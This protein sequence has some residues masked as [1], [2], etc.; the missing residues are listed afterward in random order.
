LPPSERETGKEISCWKCHKA[1]PNLDEI[2]LNDQGLWMCQECISKRYSLNLLD[3]IKT[4]IAVTNTADEDRSKFVLRELV[5]NADDA[6]ASIIVLRFEKDALYVA[7]NGRAF[8]AIGPDGTPGDFERAAAVLKRFK[9]NDPE[10]AGHFGSGFQTVYA[11]TNRPEVHSNGISRALNPAEMSWENL[12]EHRYSPYM[13]GKRGKK[14]VLFRLPWRDNE[15]AAT[16]VQ[17]E[18]P[19]SDKYSWPRWNDKTIREFYDDLKEYLH[20]VLLCAQRLQTVRIVWSA[21]ATY[22]AYEASRDYSLEKPLEDVTIVHVR[23]GRASTRLSWYKW[24]KGIAQCIECP[25][26]FSPETMDSK[27]AKLHEYI[28]ASS[29]ASDESGHPQ[30][31]VRDDGGTVA[32]VSKLT[33]KAPI[34]KNHVHLL[35]PLFLTSTDSGAKS[36]HSFLYSIIPLPRRGLNS[37]VFSAHLIPMEDRKDV[38]V[39]GNAGMNGVW[40]RYCMSEVARLYR[41]VFPHFLEYAKDLSTSLSERQRIVL[42]ALPTSE[43]G[44]WMRPDTSETDWAAGETNSLR[45]WLCAQPILVTSET[46][47]ASPLAA[48]SY[49]NQEEQSLLATLD[50]DAFPNEFTS[51]CNEVPWLRKISEERRLQPSEM[52]KVWQQVKSSGTP[53]TLRY[54]SSVELP[55]GRRLSLSL[56]SLEIL[57]RYAM[58]DE[59]TASLP[60]VPNEEGTLCDIHSFP[61]L[62]EDA[63]EVYMLLSPSRRVHP[64]F[65]RLIQ[66][67]EKRGPTRR[68]ETGISELPE[69]ISL[70]VSEQPKRF[71]ELSPE[72]FHILS[73]A[74]ALIV[75]DESFASDKTVDKAFIPYRLGE[76]LYVGSPPNLSDVDSQHIAENYQRDWIFASQHT[77]VPV[78]GLT[79]EIKAKIRFLALDGISP[80]ETSKIENRLNLVALME[81]NTPTNYV[82]HFLSGL[83][84]SLLED[85]NLKKLLDSHDADSLTAQKKKMLEALKDYFSDGPHTERGLKPKDMGEITCLYDTERVWRKANEFA[86]GKGS[87]LLTSDYA[88]LHSDFDAW[89]SKILV[90]LGVQ[91]GLTSVSGIAEEVTKLAMQPER[92]R[93][94]LSNILGELCTTLD[95]TKLKQLAQLLKS[96]AWIP[97]AGLKFAKPSEALLK[98]ESTISI[99]GDDANSFVD[100]KYMDPDVRRALEELKPQDRK[101]R[102]LSI[103]IRIEPSI[104]EMFDAMTNMARRLAVPP[105][106]LLASLSI[107]FGG[108]SP[109]DSPQWR[110]RASAGE[111][112]WKGRWYSGSRI[113]ILSDKNKLPLPV[114]PLEL[115]VLTSKEAVPYRHYLDMIG[116]RNELHVDDILRALPLL[117]KGPK[118]AETQSL[119]VSLWKQIESSSSEISTETASQLAGAEIYSPHGTVLVAPENVLLDDTGFV[120]SAPTIV[121]KSCMIPK[122]EGPSAALSRLG[123][124]RISEI[125]PTK[126]QSCLINTAATNEPITAN[127]AEAYLRLLLAMKA[128]G[129]C[130]SDRA[131]PL[132]ALSYRELRFRKPN[133]CYIANAATTKIYDNVNIAICWTSDGYQVELERL[134]A[135]WG[136]KSLSGEVKYPNLSEWVRGRSHEMEAMFSQIYS[137]L[138]I[139]F[140]NNWSSLSW[141]RTLEVMIAEG[142]TQ[143]YVVGHNKGRFIIPAIIPLD[144][145]RTGLILPNN[146][147]S[148]SPDSLADIVGAW[149]I[150]CGF[151]P[152]KIDQLKPT[153][154]LHYNVAVED[155][156]RPERHEGYSP[157]LATLESWYG[158]CQICGWRTPID[159][160]SG[161]CAEDIRSIISQRGGMLRGPFEEYEVGN[162]LYLC[163]RHASLMRRG[164]IRFNFLKGKP[165]EII[166]KLKEAREHVSDTIVAQVYEWNTLDASK[167]EKGWKKCPVNLNPLHAKAIFERLPLYYEK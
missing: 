41:S 39:Q 92:N 18:R 10:A 150:G 7:N 23:E 115:L 129:W 1:P 146:I 73:R 14:G 71:R 142:K 87:P 140:E 52:K 56:E 125:G 79:N 6:N 26:S 111:F 166:E 98:T 48:Y 33:G 28:A 24:D 153:F 59:M 97:V 145:N 100:I 46:R 93:T 27:D 66:Q 3:F 81:R 62:P 110:K 94:R 151:P 120:V 90:A 77:S 9:A 108:L 103:G 85:S 86:L 155:M 30:Y 76:S 158:G 84:G 134:A 109:N 75:L 141:I 61:K 143:T 50:L 136:S 57:I 163:P 148:V 131:A 12:P 20:A 89:D 45:D 162:C 105:G 16:V 126:A 68:K 51:L 34:K 70:S 123:A 38:D 67:L 114:A 95:D 53:G 2:E 36:Q 102:F 124:I 157:T 15:A 156:Q 29:V 42:Q 65:A 60:L 35:M 21:D 138:S 137:P 99:L 17:G 139:I 83:H 80:R 55:S 13:G 31:L 154:I 117:L 37:F 135:S 58:T 161:R 63:G 72:D 49:A 133:E 159:E 160:Y 4:R 19:F 164:L 32:V 74:V 112:F 132:P 127:Q 147:E 128:K 64:D 69:L 22:E 122:G 116:V 91:P 104:D 5:Q 11:V 149:A 101:N 54:K 82:R 106:K 167:S 47:W 121:G 40:Y 107:A 96:H 119:L 88:S 118:S 165:S 113:R 43:I 152:A 25:A 8:S 78:P 144:S 130:R 44:R